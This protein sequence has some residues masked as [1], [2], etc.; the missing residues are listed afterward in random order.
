[1]MLD[2][3]TSSQTVSVLL[4]LCCLG[5]ILVISWEIRILNFIKIV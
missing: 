4:K 3:I 5:K 2:L 1:M